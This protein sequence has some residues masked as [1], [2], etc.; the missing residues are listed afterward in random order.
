MSLISLTFLLTC[1]ISEG[2][3]FAQ[4]IKKSQPGKVKITH[5]DDPYHLRVAFPNSQQALSYDPARIFLGPEYIFL[6]NIYSPLIYM[7]HDGILQP[8]LAKSFEWNGDEATLLMRDD[9]K[10]ISGKKITADDAEFSLKRLMVLSQNTHGNLQQLLCEGKALKTVNDPCSGIRVDQNKLILTTTYPKHFLFSMLSAIDFAVISRSSVD[11]KTLQIKEMKETSGPYYVERDDSKGQI[12]L[13]ANPYHFNYHPKA[14]QTISFVPSKQAVDDFSRSRVDYITS[15][16]QMNASS[17]IEQMK[18]QKKRLFNLHKTLDIRVFILNFTK[19]GL[20][21]FDRS[22]RLQV[23]K[24]IRSIFRTWVAEQ[25]AYQNAEQFFP[26]FSEGGIDEQRIA[27]LQKEIN[28][29]ESLQKIKKSLLWLVRVDVEQVKPLLEKV[30]GLQVKAH[31][32]VPSLLKNVSEEEMPDFYISGSDTGF[33]E[34]ISLISYY[35]STEALISD[36]REGDRWLRAYMAEEEKE[37][38]LSYLRDMHFKALD[39]LQIIPM[40]AAPYVA[41]ADCHWQH[42]LSK[43]YAN[44]PLWV[45]RYQE[46]SCLVKAS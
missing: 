38:R 18:S 2:A 25:T 35:L 40:A 29:Q 10:T 30:S 41:V 3:L 22:E 37:V 4:Q 33:T 6:E 34:D 24:T 45:L 17:V 42:N 21:R 11:P 39:N 1:F 26:V 12:V 31:D 5:L 16:D 19:K 7:S 13:K 43:F 14:P 44:N 15:I 27:S 28:S 9:I 32:R 20:R 46:N 36:R 23:A 8:G